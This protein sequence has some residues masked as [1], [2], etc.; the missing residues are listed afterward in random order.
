MHVRNVAFEV[1]NM[2]VDLVMPVNF[3]YLILVGRSLSLFA[4]ADLGMENVKNQ[5]C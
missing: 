4:S 2:E 3:F 5:F 1:D